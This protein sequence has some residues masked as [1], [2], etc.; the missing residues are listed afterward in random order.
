MRNTCEDT[1]INLIIKYYTR[2]RVLTNDQLLTPHQSSA[3]KLALLTD[4]NIIS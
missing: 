1:F 4:A 3:I 2:V